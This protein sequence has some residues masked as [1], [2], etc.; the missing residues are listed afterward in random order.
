MRRPVLAVVVASAALTACFSSHPIDTTRRAT[1]PAP[2]S[3]A[4]RPASRA[5]LVGWFESDRITGEAAASIH[6]VWYAFAADGTYSGSALIRDGAHETF[7]T[8]SG[9]W[10]LDGS[11]LSLGADSPPAKAFAAE[12]RLRMDSD[13]GSVTFRRGKAE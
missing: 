7:Q 11:T 9:T 4:W 13:G 8:L 10:R 5:D 12:G 1:E 6:R 2:P 3:I